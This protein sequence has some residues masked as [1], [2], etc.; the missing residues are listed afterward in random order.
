MFSRRDG[1]LRTFVKIIFS[2]ANHVLDVN[3]MNFHYFLIKIFQL[4]KVLGD[5]LESILNFRSV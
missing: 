5:T 1:F 3:C 2:I 4:P